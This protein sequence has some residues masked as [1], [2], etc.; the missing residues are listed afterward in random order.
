QGTFH[1]DIDRSRTGHCIQVCSPSRGLVPSLRPVAP[2]GN[3]MRGEA[4]VDDQTAL[5]RN[6]SGRNHY[7]EETLRRSSDLHM[8]IAALIQRRSVM[9]IRSSARTVTYQRRQ[10]A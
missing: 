2:V 8:V 7:I 10:R 3:P 6:I 5:P 9:R 4:D 1:T